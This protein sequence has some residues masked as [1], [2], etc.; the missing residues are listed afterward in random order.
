ME[1]VILEYIATREF[2]FSVVENMIQ[3]ERIS[4]RTQSSLFIAEEFWD[5]HTVLSRQ[6]MMRETHSAVLNWSRQA[7]IE[8]AS[9]HIWDCINDNSWPF[10]SLP[11]SRIGRSLQ[12]AGFWESKEE[13]RIGRRDKAERTLLAQPKVG[14]W[15]SLWHHYV[16]NTSSSCRLAGP[17]AKAMRYL[18]TNYYVNSPMRFRRNH[19]AKFDA[20]MIPHAIIRKKAKCW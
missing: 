20:S 4:H 1:H 12:Q 10:D 15:C 5:G 3:E 9:Q 2:Q 6:E 11:G 16:Q 17:S 8:I 13:W 19:L 14:Y 18:R 7:G